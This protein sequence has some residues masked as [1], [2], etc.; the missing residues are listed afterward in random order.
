VLLGHV[1]GAAADVPARLHEAAW[2][3][4]CHVLGGSGTGKTRLLQHLI[5]D[6]LR[7]GHGLILLDPHGDLFEAAH[8]DCPPWRDAELVSLDFG[9]FDHAPSLNL[10]QCQGERAD[11]ERTFLI[12]ALCDT[13]VRMYPENQDAFGPMFFAY[14]TY[15]ARL[16]L[17][18]IE[19]RATVLDV[20][21]VFGEAGFR[22]ALVERC[23]D[24]D[25]RAFWRGIALRAGGEAS[26]ENIAP[27]I[28]SKFVDLQQ[29]PMRAF[30][31]QADSTVDLRAIM[32]RGGVLLVNLAKGLLGERQSRF[33]GLLLTSRI[34]A[35][36]LSRADLPSVTRREIHL[37]VDEFGSMMAPALAQSV[38][39]NTGSRILL[40]LGAD[41]AHMMAR[42]VAPEYGAHELMTLPDR[43]A[44]ARL[45]VPGGVT[46]PFLMRTLECPDVSNDPA[47]RERFEEL[48]ASSR[49]R[50]CRPAADV[51][52]DIA[53]R[54]EASLPPPAKAVD[55][56]Q[57]L[58][59]IV[60]SA[61]APSSGKRALADAQQ[62]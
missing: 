3:R 57:S 9:D 14:L 50:Y 24:A 40:R 1:P 38:L 27:Y 8:A 19:L 5:A 11:V 58:A 28:V 13:F 15:A 44:V 53:Q 6:R 48:R 34:L 56:T 25:V 18:D 29:P 21:R 31:G 26:L 45:Q 16:V 36:A 17:C 42:W 55:G 23:G 35:A 49:S 10:L 20:P 32:D 43:H 54:R 59:G 46:P 4:H 52:R 37:F 61:P 60:A 12:H 33:L 7:Q 39:T 2:S 51:E 62:V 30:V 47:A 41:D 22:R